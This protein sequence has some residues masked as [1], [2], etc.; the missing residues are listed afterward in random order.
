MA[1]LRALCMLLIATTHAL[2]FVV[3][4]HYRTCAGYVACARP[5]ATLPATTR[6]LRVP[7]ASTR[8]MQA[9]EDAG[10]DTRVARLIKSDLIDLVRAASFPTTAVFTSSL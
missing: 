10:E 4:V 2:A 1:V 5:H 8:R 7:A 9:A 6:T 3:P